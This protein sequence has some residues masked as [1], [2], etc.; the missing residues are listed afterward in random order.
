MSVRKSYLFTGL[1]IILFFLTGLLHRLAMGTVAWR[2]TIVFCLC[3]ILYSGMVIGWYFSIRIRLLPTRGRRY[4][5]VSAWLMMLLI[6]LRTVRYRL[7][8][9]DASFALQW[10]WIAYYVPILFI[11]TLFFLTALFAYRHSRD[12]EGKWD[13]RWLLAVPLLLFAL[14][15][16]NQWHHWV[17]VPYTGDP[18]VGHNADYGYG[19]GFYVLSV[20]CVVQVVVGMALLISLT[21]RRGNWLRGLAAVGALAAYALLIMMDTYLGMLNKNQLFKFP[22]LATFGMMAIFECCIRLRFIPYNENYEEFFAEL[23]LPAVITDNQYVARWHT[24]AAVRA[25][26]DTMRRATHAKVALD[27]NVYLC[28]QPLDAA[29]YVFYTEDKT[30]LHALDGR[31]AEANE[32]IEAE[33]HLIAT[34][35]ELREQKA[36]LDTRQRIYDHIDRVMYARQAAIT[37]L[38]SAA[39]PGTPDFR[40]TVGEVLV[41]TTY[42]KRG[43]NIL[44]AMH[45]SDTLPL[46]ELD[47]SIRESIRYMRYCGVHAGLNG[48]WLTAHADEACDGRLLFAIYTTFA[49]IA[50][51][52]L[53]TCTRLLVYAETGVMR[54]SA[55]CTTP[56]DL[57]TSPL[58]VQ[59]EVADD[60]CYFTV[61]WEVNA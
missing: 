58:P 39:R 57:G 23:Q 14:V 40:R 24:A 10:T 7:L 56:P 38:L 60:A 47:L 8:T 4:A 22:E 15:A 35:N 27:E 54:L 50:E 44:L 43:T 49:D 11:P 36:R 21:R 6:V 17:F 3:T 1:Y 12:S 33:N 46:G 16:T 41:R 19:A 18:L 37:A 61:R 52:L 20:V 13:E 2:D 48:D 25:D 45:D 51:A 5:L 59:W 28:A 31:L 29:G 53:S 9:S 32:L 30:E 34:E 26:A 55:N 42:I